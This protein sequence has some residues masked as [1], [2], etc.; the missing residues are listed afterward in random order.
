LRH[1]NGV[2]G[3]MNPVTPSMEVFSA[4]VPRQVTTG[5]AQLMAWTCGRPK[6]SCLDG[7][8]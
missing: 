5:F 4:A 7:A 2:L 8:A 3:A 6:P 1:V